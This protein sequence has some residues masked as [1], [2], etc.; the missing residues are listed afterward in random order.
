MVTKK[1]SACHKGRPL[2]CFRPRRGACK[3]CEAAYQRNYYAKNIVV[4][5]KRSAE[6][7]ANAR[8]DPVKG[9]RLRENSRRC[10]K[11]GRSVRQKAYIAKQK[12]VNFWRWKRN[13]VHLYGVSPKALRGLWEKQEQLC[14]LTG[15]PLNKDTMQIDHIIPKSRGGTDDIK[16][17][18]WVVPEANRA[19]RDLLDEEFYVLC[20]DV[21][22]FIA[23]RL[24]AVVRRGS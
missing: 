1:C 23:R 12:H 15:R 14:G 13:N 11:N 17:I 6:W 24:M 9:E 21:V 19:K 18:R 3:E 2:T 20:A 8:K 4:A 7:M 22:E 16:N 10:W 5:R